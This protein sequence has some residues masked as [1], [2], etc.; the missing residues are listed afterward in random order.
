MLTQ[1]LE[2]QEGGH[3]HPSWKTWL[4]HHLSWRDRDHVMTRASNLRWTAWGTHLSSSRAST[5]WPET[6]DFCIQAWDLSQVQSLR[7]GSLDHKTQWHWE[8]ALELSSHAGVGQ[9]HP[10]L[11]AQAS[12]RPRCRQQGQ[13]L[14]RRLRQGMRGEEGRITEKRGHKLTGRLHPSWPGSLFHPH[15]GFPLILEVL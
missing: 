13:R 7:L 15:E 6:R 2:P 4:F 14:H 1:L 11:Q 10:P 3:L 9:G 5:G 8:V 12:H